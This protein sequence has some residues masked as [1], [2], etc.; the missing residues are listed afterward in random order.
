MDYLDKIIAEQAA[1]YGLTVEQYAKRSEQ[2]AM[3]CE[4]ITE[5]DEMNGEAI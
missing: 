3:L 2:W 1:Y 5:S 4:A